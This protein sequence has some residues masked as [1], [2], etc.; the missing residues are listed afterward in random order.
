MEQLDL[1]EI[2]IFGAVADA[3]SFTGAAAHLGL[4]KSTVSRRVASLEKRL[5]VRLLQRTTRKV[6]LTD[7]GSA[8][9]EAVKRAL[10]E[11]G[12]ANAAVQERQTEPT[13]LLRMTAP[14]DLA[15]MH[16]AELVAAF[17]D[18]HP[19]VRVEMASTNRIVDLVAEG[20]DFAFRA[21]ELG[22]SSLI[23]RA[24]ARSE[25]GL[26]ASPAYLAERGVPESPADLA[27]HRLVVFG[28]S[29]TRSRYRFDSAHGPVSVDV[30]G[31]VYA[32]EFTFVLASL[33]H[34]V[35]IGPLPTTLVGPELE[36]GRLVRVLPELH[37]RSAAFHLL[38]PSAR[39]L[40]AKARLFRDHTLL[41]FRT[42]RWI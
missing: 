1:N 5:G 42:P 22:E 24:L 33:R 15:A 29:A 27:D 41:W 6:S 4:P 25:L 7:A 30:R 21:G 31:A 23:A 10:A 38:Y 2:A 32:D 17:I 9:H 18:Q 13:G 40:P 36:S 11:L 12:E 8:Y 26:F 28:A 34:G 20:F 35:G 3:E 19:G 37:R 14:A 16:L 39:Y